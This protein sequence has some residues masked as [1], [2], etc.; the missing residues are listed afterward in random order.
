MMLY[1][2]YIFMFQ[3]NELAKFEIG[4][5]RYIV[6]NTFKGITYVHI[7]QFENAAKPYPTR[8]GIAL[9]PSRFAVLSMIAEEISERVDSLNKPD[10]KEFDYK[11][12]L[13]GGIYCSVRSGCFAVNIR[14]H[15]VPP[16]HQRPI[17]TKKGISLRPSEWRKLVQHIEDIKNLS[18]TITSATPCFFNGTHDN[19]EGAFMC[20]ECFPFG[21]NVL[22]T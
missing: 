13:G 12:H 22:Y 10:V 11:V 18:A 15:F 19:Q 2:M 5:G 17:P 16:N 20:V 9:T 4:N 6:V 7:R 14:K 1:K 8:V 3:N 21:L